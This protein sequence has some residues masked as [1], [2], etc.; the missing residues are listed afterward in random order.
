MLLVTALGA[1]CSVG[2][3]DAAACAAP[4]MT[5]D[6]ALPDGFPTPG[7]VTYT[8]T[9]E[10]GPGTVVEGRRDGEVMAAADAYRNA[11]AAAGYRVTDA[12]RTE[13]EAGVGFAGGGADG[14]VKLRVCDDRTSIE[15]TV[16][17]A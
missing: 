13:D 6:P 7:G 16:R 11:L 1:G 8:A 14:R 4:R 17:T 12:G 3:D 2:D 9:R 15:I 10:E 5:G